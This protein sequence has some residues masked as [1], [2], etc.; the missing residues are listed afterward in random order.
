MDNSSADTRNVTRK[1][2][3][4]GFGASYA[5]AILGTIILNVAHVFHE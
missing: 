4:N 3:I 2:K 5:L 1:G